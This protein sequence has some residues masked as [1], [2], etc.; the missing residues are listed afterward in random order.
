MVRK[1]AVAPPALP[2]WRSSRDESTWQ[3]VIGTLTLYVKKESGYWCNNIALPL[4]L[5]GESNLLRI[6][7]AHGRSGRFRSLDKAK[8]VAL[9]AGLRIVAMQ[10]TVLLDLTNE[11]QELEDGHV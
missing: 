1:K 11:Q 5:Y 9:E 8:L 7:A 3:I 4:T 2:K 6:Q 10:N